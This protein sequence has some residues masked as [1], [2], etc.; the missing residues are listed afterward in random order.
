MQNRD[1]SEF[2][3]T[4]VVMEMVLVG[5]GSN[6]GV[7]VGVVLVGEQHPVARV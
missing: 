1:S 2:P 5:A 7:V 3:L 4:A 6:G